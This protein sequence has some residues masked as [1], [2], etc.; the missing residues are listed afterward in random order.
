MKKSFLIVLIV[1]II[2]GCSSQSPER[3]AENLIKKQLSKS[4]KGY[5][6]IKFGNLDSTFTSYERATFNPSDSLIANAPNLIELRDEFMRKE[7]ANEKAFKRE[8]KGFKMQHKFTNK[9]ADGGT[10]SNE[11]IFYFDKGI[12]KIENV[13][14]WKAEDA[15]ITRELENADRAIENMNKLLQ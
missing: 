13:V 1:I 7:D 14:D 10:V 6:S 11:Y 15:R 8:F 4:M 2:A 9:N 5:E 12:S 3:K